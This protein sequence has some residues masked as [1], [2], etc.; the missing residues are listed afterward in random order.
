MIR[1]DRRTALKGL[2]A[3]AASPLLYAC[4]KD[5]T[6]QRPLREL[7]DTVVVLMMENRS[8]DHYFG[9]LSLHEG[10]SDIDGLT[11]GMFNPRMDGSRVPIY[12]ETLGCFSDPSHSWNNSRR[13]LNGGKN[14][15]F[16]LVH[17][18]DHPGEEAKRPMGYFSRED[19]PALYGLADNFSL[20]QRWHCSVL[21]PT[22]PNRFY[23]VAGSSNGVK[24]NDFEGDFKM[25]TIFDRLM[26]AGLDFRMY[27]GNLS[28]TWMIPTDYTGHYQP[29]ATFFDDAAAGTLPPFSLVEPIYG[30]NDD[31]PPAH[32]SAGQL[33]ISS[34]YDALARS[35]QWSRT[36]FVVT[37]D[38]NG[39]FFDHV[40]PPTTEDN[41]A[42][43]GF[44]QLG[45]R[46]PSVVTGPYVKS[47]HVSDTLYDHTSVLAFVERLFDL[48]PLTKRDA[49][50]NDLSDLL[51]TERLAARAPRSPITLPVITADE[52]VIYGPDCVFD[53]GGVGGGGGGLSASTGQ[54]ELEQLLAIKP[55]GEL[56]RRR[57]A[58]RIYDELVRRAERRGLVRWRE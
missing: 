56:D 55:R 1:F 33:M 39:G 58:D 18:E 46:V 29:L 27:Y 30:K 36:L 32:P 49:A 41:F 57:H 9:S 40:A 53:V 4:D 17:E 7:I 34:V 24:R 52:A 8:F 5:E 26:Y 20:C 2:G 50:A 10:R 51:D 35:P 45:F 42:E 44:D 48:E 28:L 16:V 54:K 19:L 3:L 6:A 31:H 11:A 38:E 14:D 15:G 13:Q 37:Y 47:G 23:L 22:W 12:R 43:E 25:P 21:G